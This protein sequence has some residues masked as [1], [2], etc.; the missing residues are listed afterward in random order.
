MT[1]NLD[2]LNIIKNSI[3]EIINDNNFNNTLYQS[4]NLNNC[5]IFS[6]NII[7][8]VSDPTLNL[9]GNDN[10]EI[11]NG[12]YNLTSSSVSTCLKS[13]NIQDSIYKILSSQI[14]DKLNKNNINTNNINDINN[15]IN[16]IL[17]QE[18]DINN[19]NK[20][21]TSSVNSKEI[22]I[23]ETNNVLLNNMI[24]NMN[25][26]I[27]SKCSNINDINI[28]IADQI[29]T[30]INTDNIPSNTTNNIPSSNTTSSILG[31]VNNKF[32]I[33]SELDDI[34]SI[35]IIFIFI[36]I[37]ILFGFIIYIFIK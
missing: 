18:L 12:K 35:N 36:S 24:F 9:S 5:Q 14:V 28:K 8:V 16:I 13:T 23:E 20:C 19:I 21:Y 10:L 30:L 6:G 34:S 31:S 27:I 17:K 33:N 22:I 32:V 3:N 11:N 7:T 29:N 26:N 15:N 4:I 25:S 1:L 37:C 2:N